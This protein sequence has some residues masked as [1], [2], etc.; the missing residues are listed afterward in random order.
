[1]VTQSLI[2]T[3]EIQ[4][5]FTRLSVESLFNE[6]AHFLNEEFKTYTIVEYIENGSVSSILK[7]KNFIYSFVGYEVQILNNFENEN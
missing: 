3:I 6:V 7:S 1:M 5:E 4:S 2:K